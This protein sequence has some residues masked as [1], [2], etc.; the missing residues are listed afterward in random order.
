M[1]VWG[2][3]DFFTLFNTGGRYNP[4]TDSWTTTSTNTVPTARYEHTAVWTGS[5][6]IVWGGGGGVFNTGGR[7]N[8][9]T[10]G[11]TTTN[12]MNAPTA[13]VGHTAVW[14]GGEMIVWGGFHDLTYENTGG[15]Y[16]PVSDSWLATSIMSAPSARTG[17]TAVWTDSEMI[18]WGGINYPLGDL[19]DGGRYTPSTDAWMFTVSTNAPDRRSSH[20]A[21]WTG[22]EM[23]VWGGEVNDA[24]ASSG[25][26]YCVQPGPT[27]TPTPASCSVTSAG[28]GSVVF[29]PRTDFSLNVSD[30]VDPATLDAS[31]FTVN[32]I[33][34]DSVGL[35]NGNMTTDFTFN[36][37]PA[38]QG[39][40]TMHIAAGAFNCLFG[41]VAE[42]TCTFR[43]EAP[44]V[45]P[46][47]RPH[48]TPLPRP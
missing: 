16:N 5:E 22:T 13:R 41:P 34:A 48:P 27:P 25:G 47:P 24:F 11:W 44:R 12:T 3:H 17:H 36:T 2:G 9:S 14:T 35:L 23:I 43:F 46:T 20:S 28:C 40:N 42:F 4:G 8:P 21:V 31:D 18:I 30:P 19:N 1:I 45:T 38:V 10:D 33:P 15:R 32:G 29:V 7:Y 37:S 39:V 6:M 26:R